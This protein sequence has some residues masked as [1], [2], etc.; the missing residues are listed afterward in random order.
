[1]HYGNKF[2]LNTHMVATYH[3]QRILYR[4]IQHGLFL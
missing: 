2:L 4:G 1:M 3:R